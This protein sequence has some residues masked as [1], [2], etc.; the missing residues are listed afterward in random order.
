MNE[1]LNVVLLGGRTMKSLMRVLC[2]L[3]LCGVAYSPAALAAPFGGGFSSAGVAS[4]IGEVACHGE[5]ELEDQ[6]MTG[7]RDAYA[8]AFNG[9]EKFSLRSPAPA[10]ELMTT[11]HR[12]AIVHGHYYNRGRSD[13]ELIRYANTVLGKNY[14]PTDEEYKAL[15]KKAG[16]PYKLSPQV[17]YDL[18]QYANAEGIRYFLFCNISHIE[19]WLKNIL[20]SANKYDSGKSMAVE[21]EYYL[22]DART[23]YVYDGFS[24]ESKTANMINAIVITGGKNMPS[25]VLFQRIMEEQVK[26]VVKD[27]GND[28]LS[29]LKKV[30]GDV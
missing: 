5:D 6:F 14:R 30:G 9:S 23:G 7:L 18:K 28:G 17:A 22:V 13:A 12:D 3:M 20:F 19:V 2:L 1:V 29:K 26:D 4:V 21:L 11:V 15:R 27:M 24:R 25:N 8:D 10:P 16:T